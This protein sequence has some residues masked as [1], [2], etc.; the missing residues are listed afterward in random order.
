LQFCVDND[1]TP[2][3]EELALRLGVWDDT[4]RH[5]EEHEDKADFMAVMKRLRS[6]QK[7]DIK[8]KSLKG[9]YVSKIATLILAAEHN[10]VPVYRKEVSGIDGKPIEVEQKLSPEQEKFL[11]EGITKLF[12][13]AMR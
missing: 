1:E 5:W 9:K 8:R 3:I 7:L 13:D 4:M 12:E 6:V 10:V 2:F 11:S